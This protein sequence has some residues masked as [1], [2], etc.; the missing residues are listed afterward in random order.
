IAAGSLR[1]PRAACGILA[2]GV[3]QRLVGAGELFAAL[4]AAARVRHHEALTLAAQD[5]AQGSEAL[6]E[7]EFVRLCR[8]NGLPGPD[9]QSVRREPSGRRRYLDAEWR[10]PD[11]RRVV[12]E[13]DGALHLIVTNWYTY[14][15]RQNEV[16]LGGA[17]MLRFPSVVVRTEQAVVVDQLRRALDL[18]A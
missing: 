7:I 6:S 10:R 4:Q 17:I 18:V 16:A 8:R 2:A 11:G 1:A 12:V 3:Q 14:Q 15:L 9:R 5:I 13:I